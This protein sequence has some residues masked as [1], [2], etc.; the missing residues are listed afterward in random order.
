MESLVENV[1]E[2]AKVSN[3]RGRSLASDE[4]Y[5]EKTGVSAEIAVKRT[6]FKN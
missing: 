6:G 2:I 1:S 4:V 5:S 3:F